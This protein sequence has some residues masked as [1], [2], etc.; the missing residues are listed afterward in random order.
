MGVAA[1]ARVGQADLLGYVGKAVAAPVP[2]QD[3]ALGGLR[4]Q[5]VVERILV[6]DVRATDSSA[7]SPS[8]ATAQSSDRT[9]SALHVFRHM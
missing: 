9:A 7:R 4:L 1:P 3:A 2:E 5:V 6:P 8:Q